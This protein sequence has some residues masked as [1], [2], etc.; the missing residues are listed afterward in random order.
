LALGMNTLQVIG[1]IP[2]TPPITQKRKRVDTTTRGS[3]KKPATRF[4]KRDEGD[5]NMSIGT[6]PAE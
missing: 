3:P 2:N 5:D 4:T 1:A 6:S